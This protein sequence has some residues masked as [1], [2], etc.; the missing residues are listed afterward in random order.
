MSRLPLRLPCKHT[1]CGQCLSKAYASDSFLCPLC[2]ASD[3][4]P[5]D[6]LPVHRVIY[7]AMMK[8]LSSVCDDHRKKINW[9]CKSC[10][11]LLCGKCVAKHAGHGFVELADA[12]IQEMIAEKVGVA[13]ENAKAGLTEMAQMKSSLVDTLQKLESQRGKI[14]QNMSRRTKDIRAAIKALAKESTRAVSALYAEAKAGLTTHINSIAEE[15]EKRTEAYQDF[16]STASSIKALDV[17][18]QLK[19]VQKIAVLP[20]FEEYRFED[21][22]DRSGEM[23]AEESRFLNA[24]VDLLQEE[25][26][27]LNITAEQCEEPK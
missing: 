12:Q 19:F 11:K 16:A 24:L 22:Q 3:R 14:L 1:V 25:V 26:R 23:E 6:H 9:Y 18:S 15:V 10:S 17:C 13:E 27:T 7:Q 5:L 8:K 20:A 4:I 2:G 21:L